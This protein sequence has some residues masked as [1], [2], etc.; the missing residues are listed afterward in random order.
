MRHLRTARPH[1]G[2]AE[3]FIQTLTRRWAHGAIYGSY[4]ERTATLPGWL[5]T[6]TSP[7]DTAP[8][9]TNRP[10]RAWPSCDNV[11]GNYD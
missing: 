5:T 4:H 10:Q 2:K 7:D 1:N 3:R 8:S 9:A 11:P 6:T